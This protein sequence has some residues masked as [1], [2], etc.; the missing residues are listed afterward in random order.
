MIIVL[1]QPKKKS[2]IKCLTK[3]D[4]IGFPPAFTVTE[5]V[6]QRA[7][8]HLFVDYINKFVNFIKKH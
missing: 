2:K 7:I 6:H 1:M 8:R 3:N 5:C 4:N